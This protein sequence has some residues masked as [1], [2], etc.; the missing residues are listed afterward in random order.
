MTLAE[1]LNLSDTLPTDPA[2]ALL[3]VRA[4]MNLLN[5]R[6]ITIV[7]AVHPDFEQVVCKLGALEERLITQL[8]QF[9]TADGAA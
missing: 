9:S 3:A 5:A 4:R 1:L 6:V 8:G 2:A 7:S